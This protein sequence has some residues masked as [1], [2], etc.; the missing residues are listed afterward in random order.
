MFADPL[1]LSIAGENVSFARTKIGPDTNLY[2][3]ADGLKTFSVK[4]TQ[5]ASRFRREVRLSVKKVA[6]DPIS[7]V[8]KEIG[9]SAYM[10]IDEPKSGFN[11]AEL[12]L[13]VDPIKWFLTE[14]TTNRV[15]GGEA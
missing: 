3:T 6:A 4:Q 14:A 7:S 1:I 11:D 8:N 15:L 2:S 10:V 13:L 12:Y 9:A 5:T